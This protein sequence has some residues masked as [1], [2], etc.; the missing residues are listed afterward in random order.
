MPLFQGEEIIIVEEIITSRYKGLR[1][2]FNW[3]ERVEGFDVVKTVDG[4][5]IKLFS[6]A[7]QSVPAKGWKLAIQKQGDH[8]IWTLY[9]FTDEAEFSLEDF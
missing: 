4:R 8:Y 9:G 3:S 2:P 7:Q 1:R 6:N 5:Q